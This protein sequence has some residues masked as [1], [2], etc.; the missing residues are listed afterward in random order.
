MELA[1][2]KNAL[3]VGVAK[4]YKGES[5]RSTRELGRDWA[6]ARLR[7]AGL[8]CQMHYSLDFDRYW[9]TMRDSR[10]CPT[11]P[12]RSSAEKGGIEDTVPGEAWEEE[13]GMGRRLRG[14]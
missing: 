9:S 14:T 2:G 12:S 11:W 3:H 1:S 4:E 13:R 8:P 5:F 7:C 6:G 10:K